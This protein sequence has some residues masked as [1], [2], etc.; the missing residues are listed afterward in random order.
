[1]KLLLIMPKFFDYPDAI[2]QELEKL[3][4]EVDFFDDRP[5]TKGI[6]KAVIRVNKNLISSYIQKY[7]RRVMQTVRT[8]QYDVV[9]LISGQ[10]L[11]FSEK[12]MQELKQAQPQADFV[13]YQWDSVQNFPSIVNF[14]RF[15][16]RKFSFDHT[17]CQAYPDLKFLPLFYSDRYEKIGRKQ[18]QQFRYDFSFVGTAHPKKYKFIRKMSAQL[19]KAYPKQFIYFFFPSR[20]VYYYRKLCNPELRNASVQEFHFTPLKGKELD[21]LISDS[22]CI[23]DS[24]QDRQNGL[25]IRV[26]E[27]LGAKKKLIT[28]N[29]N[30]KNYDFYRPENIYIYDGTFDFSSVF[31][32]SAY[33]EIPAEIYQKYALRSWLKVCLRKDSAYE[34]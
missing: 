6:V 8:K 13:L 32:Q 5:S 23:L 10:S 25:T 2:Q 18:T 22:R 30:I 28:T 9:F 31:F 20:I 24:A 3:G 15:F 33:Q 17:D 1:M 11:C 19:K 26:I 27:A 14:H 16:D 4:Y 21:K 7:F 29:Q 34:Y 12:M